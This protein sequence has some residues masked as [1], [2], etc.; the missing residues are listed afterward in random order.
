MRRSLF[1]PLELGDLKLKNR[2]VMAPMTRQR[3]SESGVPTSMMTIYYEQRSSAGLILTDC[4]MVHPLARAYEGCPG[5]FSS[6]Q[7][8]GWRSVTEAVHQ[9]AGVIF[10]QLWHCGRRSHS[11]LLNGEEPVAPSAVAEPLE[12][13]TP[14]GMRP[15]PVPHELSTGE[16]R[17]VI[18]SF[19]DAAVNARRAGFDGIELHGA[20]GYL[21]DQ[22]LREGSNRRG[23]IYGGSLGN[24]A[25][26]L[27]ELVEAVVSVWGSSRV[28]IKLSPGNSAHGMTDSSPSDL[29]TYVT[30]APNSQPLAY[31]HAF[32]PVA[33]PEAGVNSADGALS[34]LDAGYFRQQFHGPLMANGGYDADTADAAVH[35]GTADLVSF[36]RLFVANPD[37]PARIARGARLN[38]PKVEAFFGGSEEGY[39]DYP[40]LPKEGNQTL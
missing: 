15:A 3:A 10:A 35:N 11:L 32:N 7:V 37:L 20:N 22:F 28:G 27:L 18:Q 25:R 19:A 2:I 40:F 1:L 36:A 21:I 23:D 16:V 13:R 5:L 9:R 4:T 17:A 8:S 6:E 14:S 30:R 29:F 39:T 24:R 33:V 12:I 31:L 34:H 38:T 26:F